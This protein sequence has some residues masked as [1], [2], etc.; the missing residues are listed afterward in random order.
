MKNSLLAIIY[1]IGG[2]FVLALAPILAVIGASV[3]GLIF[4]IWFIK[5]LL[6]TDLEIDT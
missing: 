4:S 1:V 5:K 3:G 6:D 2:M